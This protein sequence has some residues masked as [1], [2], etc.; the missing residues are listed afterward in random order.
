[1][2]KLVHSGHGPYG[3]TYTFSSVADLKRKLVRWNRE[4]NDLEH[5]GLDGKTPN[6]A[7]K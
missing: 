5:C 6:E 4:Y 3:G 2:A 1:M 7:H